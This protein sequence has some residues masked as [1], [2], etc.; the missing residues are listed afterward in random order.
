[1][2]IFSTDTQNEKNKI[3][4]RYKGISK[5]ELDIIPAKSQEDFYSTNTK[6]RVGVYVRVSTE[7]PRQT[8]SY[9][10]QKNHYQDMVLKRPDWT[11]VE[12]YADEGISGTSLKNRNAFKKMISD[13]KE[14]KLDLIVTKS[15]SRFARN[16][17]DC[18]GYVRELSS[19][20]PPVGVFFET[21]NIY[22]LNSNAE[23]TLSFISTLAQEESHTKSE[24]MNASIEMRFSRGIFL[25]PVLLGYDH[26]VNG[27]LIINE[28]EARI[29]EL[30]FLLYYLGY[31]ASYISHVFNEIG[32]KSKTGN[33]SWTPSSIIS[34]LKNE[35]YCGDILARKT[36]TPNY[37]DHKSKKN[38]QNR[39]QY[40]QKDHHDPI[41]ERDLFIAVQH[42]IK[43]K[44]YGNVSSL[45]HIEIISNGILKGFMRIH[46]N[47]A[48]YSSNDY[49]QAFD[50]MFFDEEPIP[51]L[52]SLLP[53]N[54]NFYEFEILRSEFVD[55]NKKSFLFLSDQHLRFSSENLKF[56]NTM[57]IDLYFNP[58]DC[59]L[60][61]RPVIEK[62]NFSIR[63]ACKNSLSS[64]IIPG[65]AFL[66]IL[67]DLFQLNR[68][69]CYRIIGKKIDAID[70][71]MLLFDFAEI[72][73]LIPIKEMVE[74]FKLEN[75][76]THKNRYI[77]AYPKAWEKTF[78]DY[79][80]DDNKYSEFNHCSINDFNDYVCYN[81]YKLKANS[82]ELEIRAEYLIDLIKGDA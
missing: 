7:D 28:K 65:T 35:R 36:W 19:L 45:P 24:I 12:I 81:Q 48:G 5:E 67:Y 29:V 52:P 72:E 4:E 6:K 8:T 71:R 47:W 49:M 34:L 21:E 61:V 51:K 46:P 32:C 74:S 57:Y 63:W 78:G 33:V 42:L 75:P 15:V 64:R 3:R 77:K 39:N 13:C 56:L 38:R 37:L 76:C 23:M 66:P 68:N 55:S 82:S 16:I 10:L 69:Y 40:L 17:V 41:I 53:M 22:T 1:M 31:T 80:P 26:D 18:I 54:S 27:H 73:T 43:N 20:T 79:I 59:Y 50:S 60:L 14:G 11:L 58:K 44:K 9:E 62:N 70:S 2:S 30:C 25:T